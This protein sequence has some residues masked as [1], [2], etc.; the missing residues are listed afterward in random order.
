MAD[1]GE[2]TLETIGL[3]NPGSLRI[4]TS[5]G[6]D[7][8]WLLL[9]DGTAIVELANI[10]GITLLKEFDPMNASTY[11]FGKVLRN[12]AS[13]PR[14]H[15]VLLAL[16]GSASTDGGA[17]AITALGAHLR[18]SKGKL[19]EF[20]GVHLSELVSIDLSEI[21][22]RPAGGVICLADVTNPL[23]GANGSARVFAPQKGA[24]GLQVVQLED[25][26]TRFLEVSGQADFPGA[27]AAGG[28]PFGLKLAWNSTLE[29][30]AKVVARLIDLEESMRACDL[31]ITGEGRLDSQSAL[32][33]VIGTL[34][35]MA[36]AL[37]KTIN[38]CV[39]SSEGPLGPEGITLLEL[40]GSY[41]SAMQDCR[42]WLFVAGAELAKRQRRQSTAT[43]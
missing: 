26:L 35:S 28:T 34:C 42:Q 25:S 18:D 41:E 1:G 15:T 4:P 11:E 21:A 29:S 9:S 8:Y 40:A 23:L 24:N 38:Y 10:C 2:G 16:G 32:G 19:I 3:H 14:V 43:V 30:G 5:A 31:I 33:K 27:G 13:D 7:S 12:V 6:S 37:G 36:D 20:G 17:G 22:S 39:G